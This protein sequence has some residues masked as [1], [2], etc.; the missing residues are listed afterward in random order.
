[1]ARQVVLCLK[2]TAETDLGPYASEYICVLALNE[3]GGLIDKIVQF[4]DSAHV[5]DR[6]K[7]LKEAAHS[8]LEK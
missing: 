3:D 2:S 4:V 7:A 6:V 5:A 8:K 1:M